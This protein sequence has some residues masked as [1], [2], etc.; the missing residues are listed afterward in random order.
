MSGGALDSQGRRPGDGQVRWDVGKSLWFTLMSLGALVG[1]VPTFTPS[2]FVLFAVTTALT[3]CAGHSVGIHRLL[4]H[5]AFRVPKWL[6]YVLVYLGVLVGL[7][8]PRGLVRL[9][10]TRDF[11][12]NEP[13]CHDYFAHR[14][15]AW[16]DYFWNLHCRFEFSQPFEPRGDERVDADAFHGFLER[17]W[18]LQQLPWALLLF[19]LGGVPWL[20]WGVFVRVTVST[21]GHWFVGYVAHRSGYRG[22]HNAGAAVQGFNSLLLGALSMGEG[23]H[24]NHHAFPSSA[25]LGIQWWELDLGWGFIALLRAVG[26]ATDVHLPDERSQAHHAQPLTHR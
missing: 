8:G 18:R 25:R 6:E 26:L 20:V 13:W 5:K 12:Q 3:L 21:V 24:N 1:A 9:H 23:W 17:T 11:H 22:W 14:Q 2:A 10:Q 7:G 15:P 19:A 4:I 16:R